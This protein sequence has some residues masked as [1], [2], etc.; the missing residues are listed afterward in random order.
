MEII[1]MND[2][3]DESKVIDKR[4]LFNDR[5]RRIGARIKMVRSQKDGRRGN[6][7]QNWESCS[8]QME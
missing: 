2:I 6:W 1:E 3:T 4:E 7:A 8:I 5:L